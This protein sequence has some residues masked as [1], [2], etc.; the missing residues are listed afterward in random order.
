M[1]ATE[2]RTITAT[3]ARIHGRG[4]LTREQPGTWLNVSKL[5][6]AGVTIPPPGTPV[7]VTLDAAGF[8]RAIAADL[9]SDLQ[10]PLLADAGSGGGPPAAAS[11]TALVRA[12]LLCCAAGLLG[13]D[14]TVAGVIE[15]AAQLEGWCRR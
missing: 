2:T 6:D 1:A 5:A 12:H 14:A 10:P 7:R 3:I 8:V 15:V 4:F 11:E 9:D 13:P